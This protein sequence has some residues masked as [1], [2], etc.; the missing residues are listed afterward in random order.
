M[1]AESLTVRDQLA[2]QQLNHDFS[3]YLDH[4]M[5]D[6]LVGL[7]TRDAYY[8][9]GQRISQ[10]L[11]EITALFKGRAEQGDRVARHIISGLRF[12]KVIDAPDRVTGHSVVVTWAANSSVP[13]A[14]ADPFLVADFIDEYQLGNDDQWR[15][16]RREIERIF[17][18]PNNQGP[19]NPS[20]QEVKY[21]I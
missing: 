6:R 15:I 12:E 5:I 16:R 17:V 1:R 14:S 10:G 18:A 21:G 7:F 8:R 2:L 20:Q 9:H 3:Y 4:H 13:V 11:D 19:V